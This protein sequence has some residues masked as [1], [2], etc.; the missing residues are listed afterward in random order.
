MTPDS[1]GG[2][3]KGYGYG[4]TGVTGTQRAALVGLLGSAEGHG[5]QQQA[6]HQPD[7]AA[8]REAEDAVMR[9]IARLDGTAST[10]GELTGGKPALLVLDIWM[11]GGGMDGLELLDMVK[12]LD[13]ETRTAVVSLD[14]RFNGKRILGHRATAQLRFVGEQHLRSRCPAACGCR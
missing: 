14:A 3:G 8:G 10:L 2:Y 5:Q 9:T 11:Q 4:E 7:H 6:D 12:S 1:G 13:P